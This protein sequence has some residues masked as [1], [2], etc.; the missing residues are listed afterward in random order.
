METDIRIPVMIFQVDMIIGEIRK[1]INMKIKNILMK[2][3]GR[4]TKINIMVFIIIGKINHGIK[5][6]LE[7][8]GITEIITKTVGIMDEI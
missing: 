8:I 6:I 7:I 2:V 1:I 5:E 3:T 4:I